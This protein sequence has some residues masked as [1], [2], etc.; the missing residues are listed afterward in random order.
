MDCFRLESNWANW[1][2]A[3]NAEFAPL[4]SAEITFMW[5]QVF[6]ECTLKWKC[7]TILCNKSIFTSLSHTFFCFLSLNEKSITFQQRGENCIKEPGN[8]EAH[9]RKQ[10]LGTSGNF[11][12]G[13]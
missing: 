12:L 13:I 5:L 7:W 6:P 3:L 4:D 11:I 10:I 8:L 1:D 2:S 9:F